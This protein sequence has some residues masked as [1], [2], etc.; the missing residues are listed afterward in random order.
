MAS[1]SAQ[2]MRSH[3]PHLRDC[4]NLIFCRILRFA[5]R[6]N[7]GFRELSADPAALTGA[8]LAGP[9]AFTSTIYFNELKRTAAIRCS[10]VFSRNCPNTLIETRLLRAR[11][12]FPSLSSLPLDYCI[13]C[14]VR[15]T[16]DVS[17]SMCISGNVPPPPRPRSCSNAQFCFCRKPSDSPRFSPSPSNLRANSDVE[18]GLVGRG[19]EWAIPP[20]CQAGT[21]HYRLAQS[22]RARAD[23]RNQ[24]TIPREV[25]RSRALSSRSSCRTP[26]S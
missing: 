3:S 18:V 24:R 5:F 6:R 23:R 20:T 25:S 12:D 16:L 4:A 19:E 22:R 1:A 9:P 7:D 26:A 21:A 10:H 8:I 13:A 2:I 15:T 11:N 14:G 17:S